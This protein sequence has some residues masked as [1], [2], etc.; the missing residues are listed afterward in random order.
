MIDIHNHIIPGIDDGAQS[1]EDSLALLKL[2][3]DNGIQKLVCTPH[4]HAGRFE[5]DIDTILP[6]F[7]KLL[8]A[9]SEQNLPIE[10]A[11]AAEVRISDE[12]MIQLK[13]NKVPMLGQWQGSDCILLE[14]PHAQIPMGIEN[15]INWLKRQNIRPVIA[16]PERNKEI[17]RHPERAKK[18]AEK[19]A[20]FQLTAGSIA[21]Q[22]GSQ[23]EEIS[24]W[25]LDNKLA[26]FVASD[27]HNTTRRPPA[28]KEAA[29]VLDQWVG[30]AERIKLTFSNPDALTQS[31]FHKQLSTK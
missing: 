5:N 12:F 20:L 14:M 16:H 3:V 28:M 1:I 10:I 2:A 26:Q 30:E 21:G 9:K 31:I 7:I 15:L 27:A 29:A 25:L 6:P 4:M 11:M 22:F 18:L 17:M 13:K 23:A 24:K 8:S 19:G